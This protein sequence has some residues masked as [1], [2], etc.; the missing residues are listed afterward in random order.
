MARRT[1]RQGAHLTLF[2][3]GRGLNRVMLDFTVAIRKSIYG[4]A[5]PIQ[6][7]L[8]GVSKVDPRN[9][10]YVANRKDDCGFFG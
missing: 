10:D 1:L 7:R 2:R 6:S 9:V 8:W 4:T 3:F 5:R